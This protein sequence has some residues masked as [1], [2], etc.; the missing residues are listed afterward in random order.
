MQ[1]GA[2]R[3]G[4]R[5]TAAVACATAAAACALPAAATAQA[6]WRP[7]VDTTWQITLS[8]APDLGA[9]AAGAYEMDGADTPAATVAAVHAKGAKA[10]CYFS[11][12][13][14]ER[15]R[16]DAKRFPKALLGR[17][18]DGWP[19]ERWIDVRRRAALRP[20]LAARMDACV[21][22]GFDAV[23]PDNVDGYANRTG[24]PLRAADQLAYNRMLAA[25][26]HGRGLAIALKN[27]ADQVKALAPVFDLAVVEQCHRYDEC[28]AYVPF[29]TRGKPVFAIEYGLA[30]SSFCPA[31]QRLGLMAARK[32]MALDRFIEPCWG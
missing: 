20:L 17:G 4:R 5:I 7:T 13:S 24:F 18:L 16:S 3:I 10:I 8:Q 6:R 21:R 11:A 1:S 30:T 26:A 29:V 9:R 12:G 27:D 22:K 2:T 32:R 19:G 28:E 31:A 15:W 25:M 23:D 14:W